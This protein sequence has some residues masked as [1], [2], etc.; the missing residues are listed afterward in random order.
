MIIGMML[1][2]CTLQRQPLKKLQGA[3]IINK[4]QEKDGRC[5]V[6]L[7]HGN[8]RRCRIYDNIRVDIHRWI[9][10]KKG[11]TVGNP[12]GIAMR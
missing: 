4:W 10:W 3:T 11:D 2:S 1:A 7:Q 12:N 5:Y 6:T 9:E 8:G